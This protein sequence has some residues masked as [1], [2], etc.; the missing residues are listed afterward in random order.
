MIHSIRWLGPLVLSAAALVAADAAAQGAAGAAAPDSTAPRDAPAAKAGDAPA[1]VNSAADG[2]ADDFDRS[3]KDC[4]TPSNIKETKVID[5][6]TILF[7][8]RGS[9][10]VTYR[11]AMSHEC[12]NLAREN[13][14]SY[15]TT[16]NRLCDSDLITVLEQYGVGL[17]EGFTCRLGP[18][19]PIPYEEAEL[20][21][22]E[23]DKPSSTQGGIK[24][25]PAEVAPKS[26]A[27]PAASEAAPAAG[28][29]AP[30]TEQAPA[31]AP[32]PA[33]DATPR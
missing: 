24:T 29:P 19:Y 18:F 1:A 22:K 25:K 13:R 15:K 16:M 30:A 14:F 32:A 17:R 21:R 2:K 26:A 8:M 20:L 9:S 6:S 10:K 33:G 4:I 27:P 5:D 7:Y 12:P 11:I 28:E 23:H 31:S 3:P